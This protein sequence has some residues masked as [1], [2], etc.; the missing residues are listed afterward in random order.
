MNAQENQHTLRQKLSRR[1]FVK[2]LI[3]AGTCI[4]VGTGGAIIWW[5]TQPHPLHTF[6]KDVFALS[7]SPGSQQLAAIATN[8]ALQIW[9]TTN[10]IL[11]HATS[12]LGNLPSGFVAWSPNGQLIATS[13]GM[14]AIQIWETARWSP[15]MQCSTDGGFISSLAWSPDSEKIA[16][17]TSNR[18]VRVYQVGGTQSG[19][20]LYT[21]V[22]HHDEVSA[23]AWSPDGTY[24]ASGSYDATIRVWN[25]S[26][27]NTITTYTG[28]NGHPISTLTW[29]PDSQLIASAADP[30]EDNIQPE[31]SAHVWQ[32]TTGKQIYSYD[33]HQN[34]VHSLAW[35][36][37][38]T[39][40]A[41]ASEDTTVHIWK[42][43]ADSQTYVYH[44]HSKGVYSVV[45]KP[46]AR[47]LASAGNE[48]TVQ[49]WLAD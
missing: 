18:E 39:R 7:W 8:G 13:S 25:A 44:G 31:Y 26:T 46:D 24:I 1:T 17:G 11:T 28:H 42:P 19:K 2:S 38:G 5:I 4:G 33:G 29:S 36:P 48:G 22:Q 35:E 16:L 15:G 40:I 23:L 10:Y 9:N 20:F 14:D 47:Q 32:A 41:S 30:M 3:A 27:Q 12:T 45:W 49:I 37:H 21:N 6:H 43:Q 34:F